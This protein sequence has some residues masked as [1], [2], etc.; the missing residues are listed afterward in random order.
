MCNCVIPLG[1]LALVLAQVVEGALLDDSLGLSAV[2]PH[3]PHP[4]K[5][6]TRYVMGNIVLS[7]PYCNQ[8][9]STNR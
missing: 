9:V 6:N 3:A 4:S 7:D 8:P 5:A 2:L 1:E